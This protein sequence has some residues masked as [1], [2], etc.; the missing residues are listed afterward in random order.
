MIVM[1]HLQHDIVVL[2]V[3]D[4]AALCDFSVEKIK[5]VLHL[6]A[7]TAANSHNLLDIAEAAFQ[8]QTDDDFIDRL[9]HQQL[10]KFT[11]TA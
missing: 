10:L 7:C 2:L 8:W 9:V 11:Q 4:L 6:H 1:H 3:V 5:R